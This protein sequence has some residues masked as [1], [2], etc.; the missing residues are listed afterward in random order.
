MQALQLRDVKAEQF[1]KP[2]WLSL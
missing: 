1:I 2:N